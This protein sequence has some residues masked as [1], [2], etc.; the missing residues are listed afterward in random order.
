M[1]C[2]LGT[3]GEYVMG[4]KIR[5]VNRQR[6]MS[7]DGRDC[8]AHIRQGLDDTPHGTAGERLVAANDGTERMRGCEPRQEAHRGSR[9]D[10]VERL[11]RGA[12]PAQ[13]QALHLNREAGGRR[14]SRDR[15]AERLETGQRG[16]AVRSGRVP[17]EVGR[18]IGNRREHRVAV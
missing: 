12:E 10:G 6:R 14:T 3:D 5:A 1:T 2:A 4:C 16:G 8:R 13:A 7:V 15:D 17:V 11:A 9:V 18:A